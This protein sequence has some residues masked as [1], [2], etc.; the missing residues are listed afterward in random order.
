MADAVKPLEGIRV[1]DFSQVM[2]GPCCTQTLGDYGADVIKIE[3]ASGDLSRTSQPDPGGLDNPVFLSL[4]RNKRSMVLN[5]KS[6]AGKQIIYD[7]VKRS[8]VVVSNFRAGVMDRLGFGYEELKAI[9]PRI[10]WASGSA[11]GAVGPYQHKAGVDPIAQAVTGLIDRRSSDDT[12][13][14]IYP[15]SLCDYSA[16]MHLVQGILLAILARHQ[17]GVGQ[18]VE[19]SLYDSMLAMQMQEATSQ[20]MRGVA[21]NWGRMPLNGVFE[22]TDGHVMMIGAFRDQPLRDI[23]TALELDEDLSGRPEFATTE[24]Q[25][26]NMAHL[27]AIFRER[28]ATNSTDYWM[29]RLEGVDLMCSRIRTLAEALDD[30]QTAVN[31]MIVELDHP[32][33]GRFA[34]IGSPVHMSDSPIQLRLAPPRLG[35]H[36]DELMRELGYDAAVVE[37][38]KS[39]G[40]FA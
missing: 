24:L 5:T 9:N 26:A 30:E 13:M 35:E 22:T 18:K 17:T 36:V 12:P 2:M 20:L 10:I 39:Q 1:L 15:T 31:G 7:L 8:D 25:F 33:Q 4:N 37:D 34:T 21:V 27:Q 23:S 14:S 29:K 38:L 11:Y 6:A 40:V 28:F 19:V 16:S 32:T 3:R